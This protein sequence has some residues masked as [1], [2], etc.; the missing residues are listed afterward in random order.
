MAI[1]ALGGGLPNVLG[2]QKLKVAR[3][4]EY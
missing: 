2:A 3:E 4:N 1:E